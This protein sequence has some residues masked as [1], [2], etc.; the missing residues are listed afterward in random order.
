MQHHQYQNRGRKSFI[1]LI[2]LFFIVCNTM[3]GREEVKEPI[4]IV[5]DGGHEAPGGVEADEPEPR[6]SQ[7]FFINCLISHLCLRY[8]E[9]NSLNVHKQGQEKLSCIVNLFL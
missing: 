9:L 2:I 1:Q 7:Q 6:K 8:P 4:V 3:A 5:W